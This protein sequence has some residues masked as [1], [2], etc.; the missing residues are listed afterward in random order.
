MAKIVFK[1]RVI[2]GESEVVCRACG[3]IVEERTPSYR[4]EM[5]YCGECGK[6]VLDL[7]QKYCMWCGERFEENK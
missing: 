6:C 4:T 3:E 2:S 5:P 7:S 1:N